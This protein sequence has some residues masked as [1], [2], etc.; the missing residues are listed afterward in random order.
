MKYVFTPLFFHRT[1]TQDMKA[2]GGGGDRGGGL[3]LGGLKIGGGKKGKKAAAAGDPRTPEQVVVQLIV[4]FRILYA[5]GVFR[6]LLRAD[7]TVAREGEQLYNV[8]PINAVRH[9]CL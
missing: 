9:P 6:K 8:W 3:S 7:C 4:Y 5:G 2:T 1:T